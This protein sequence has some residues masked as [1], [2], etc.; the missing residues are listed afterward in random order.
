MNKLGFAFILLAALTLLFLP[1]L[2][3]QTTKSGGEEFLII[4]SVD[5][6]KH[7]VVCKKP[8]EVT[9][10]IM[11]SDRTSIRDEYAKTLKLTDLR[12]GDTVWMA[13]TSPHSEGRRTAISIRKGPMTVE[14]L[15]RLYLDFP[16]K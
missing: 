5:Q 11:I 14:A 13:A 6:A 3:A 10:L 4:S 8:T 15:H 7:Q 2:S 1:A 16:P 9:V 12:A